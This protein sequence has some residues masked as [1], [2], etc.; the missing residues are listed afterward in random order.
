MGLYI[1]KKMT[2]SSLKQSD[3]T[4]EEVSR[5]LIRVL[6]HG[7]DISVDSRGWA[8]TKDIRVL[9]R[10]KFPN[11]SASRLLEDVLDADENN[12]FQ[13]ENGDTVS[14][15]RATRKHSRPEVDLIDPE[16]DEDELRWYKFN[17]D[18]SRGRAWVQATSKDVAK[19]L[20]TRRS[21]G[22]VL[23]FNRDK[24]SVDDIEETDRDRVTESTLK[25]AL[26][27]RS[28]F[29]TVKIHQSADKYLSVDVRSNMGGYKGE[30]VKPHPRRT[31]ERLSNR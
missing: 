6:R 7:S 11:K 5:Y 27:K 24:I 30:Y 4:V 17:P 25:S 14:F 26:G 22:R 1:N 15:I 31:R 2:R 10:K 21:F 12:R 18:N 3:S 23:S 16:P 13:V 19:K 9:L 28:G 29:S 8:N 20:M